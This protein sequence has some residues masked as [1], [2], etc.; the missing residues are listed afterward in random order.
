VREDLAPPSYCQKRD[1]LTTL[2]GFGSHR[3]GGAG[4][5]S[6]STG[7]VPLDDKVTQRENAYRSPVLELGS[8]TYA[9]PVE[10][11]GRL[12]GRSGTVR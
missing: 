1:K 12:G 4:I 6:R 10:G 7:E 9:S 8:G 5:I 2:L 3:V 11:N